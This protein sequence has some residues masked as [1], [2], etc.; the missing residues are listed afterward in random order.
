M[1]TKLVLTQGGSVMDDLKKRLRE[2]LSASMFL[3]V[4]ELVTAMDV[5]RKEAAARDTNAESQS[6]HIIPLLNYRKRLLLLRR[7]RGMLQFGRDLALRF[8]GGVVD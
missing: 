1:G 6:T 7:L 8:L 5:Q 4:A 3:N 2:P